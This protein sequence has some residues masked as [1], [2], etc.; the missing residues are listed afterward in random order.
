MPTTTNQSGELLTFLVLLAVLLIAVIVVTA[1]VLYRRKQ[2]GLT[3]KNSTF[4]NDVNG[5]SSEATPPTN[6]TSDG[7]DEMRVRS[8]SSTTRN[9]GAGNDRPGS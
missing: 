8:G 2:Q 4:G 5:N 3:V 9:S 1:V 6:R 7:A